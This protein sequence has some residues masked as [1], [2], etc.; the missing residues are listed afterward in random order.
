MMPRGLIE[1]CLDRYNRIL[2]LSDEG[3]PF[4]VP[5]FNTY[6]GMVR[7]EATQQAR[8]SADPKAALMMTA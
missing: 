2:K 4:H 3:D 8:L 5:H 7:G 1:S 6:K